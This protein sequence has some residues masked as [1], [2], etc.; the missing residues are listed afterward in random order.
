MP[1]DS[2]LVACNRVMA[3]ESIVRYR[4]NSHILYNLLTKVGPEKVKNITKELV[5]HWMRTAQHSGTEKSN[6]SKYLLCF[7]HVNR[8]DFY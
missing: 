3:G 6:L 7:R 5:N 8:R 4:Q 1:I 2:R